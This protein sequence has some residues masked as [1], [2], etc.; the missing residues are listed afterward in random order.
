MENSFNHYGIG[1]IGEWMWETI[2]GISPDET[3]PGWR[4]FNVRPIPGGGLTSARGEYR[5]IRGTIRV[6]WRIEGRKFLLKVEI[7]CNTTAT[8]QL[9]GKGN[10]PMCVGSGTHYFESVVIPANRA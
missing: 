9:P 6:D 3:A 5:S 1:S 7:P 2:I 8:L 10:R 4:H